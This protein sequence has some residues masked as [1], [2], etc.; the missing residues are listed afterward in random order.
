MRS[1]TGAAVS[2]STTAG[3]DRADELGILVEQE[4]PMTNSGKP[5]PDAY[6]EF[7]AGIDHAVTSIVKQLRKPSGVGR[8]DRRE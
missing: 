6:P 1:V 7:L 8:L 2:R 4:F 5:W 3:D